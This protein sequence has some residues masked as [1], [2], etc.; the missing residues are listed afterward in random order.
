MSEQEERDKG[1]T[2]N[3]TGVAA[4]ALVSAAA[5]GAATYGV[6]KALSRND[7]D[8]SGGGAEDDSPASQGDER[9]GP[10]DEE[11]EEGTPEART[12]DDDDG[13]DASEDRSEAD[14]EEEYDGDSERQ[15]SGADPPRRAVA[16]ESK[17]KSVSSGALASASHALVP[18]A[19]GA[20]EAAGRYVAE[21][22]PDAVRDKLVPRFIEAFEKAS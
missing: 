15:V 4:R 1:D 19:E 9:E 16:A 17:L 2:G 5:A 20:A 6:R 7:A 11:N 8:D 14:E 21:H 3:F 10:S 12:D 13:D 22:A 18:L